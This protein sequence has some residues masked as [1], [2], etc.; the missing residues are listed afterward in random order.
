MLLLSLKKI[1]FLVYIQTL[2]KNVCALPLQVSA[3][4]KW[5]Q[6]LQRAQKSSIFQL[7]MGKSTGRYWIN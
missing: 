3:V 1:G 4:V 7:Q 2:E 6:F 5:L